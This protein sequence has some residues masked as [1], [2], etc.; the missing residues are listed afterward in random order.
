MGECGVSRSDGK[1][2]H[3][4]GSCREGEH[5]RRLESAARRHRAGGG[6]ANQMIRAAALGAILCLRAAAQGPACAVSGTVVD[7]ANKPVGKARVLA[8]GPNYS[9]WKSTDKSGFFCFDHIEP[10]S[11]RLSVEKAGYIS[12][13]RRVTIDPEDQSARPPL[14]IA[15]SAEAAISGVVLDS[16][17]EPIPGAAVS[18]WTRART[19]KGF[20]PNSEEGADTGPD[21]AFSF[22]DLFPG[23]YY[24]SASHKDALQ[25]GVVFPILDS[26]GRPPSEIEMETFY[27]GSLT[28]A[29][30]TPLTLKPGQNVNNLI[31]MVRK[32]AVRRLAGRAN[33]PP[34]TASLILHE[35]TETSSNSGG[36]IPIGADGSFSR[37]GLAPARY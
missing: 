15:I 18:V 34:S 32:T 12:A 16:Y 21:G 6:G 14:R 31:L 4:S 10:G 11:Y 8:A 26:Q 9:L 33:A 37:D 35:D 29:G 3:G 30:A 22:S 27:G 13:H 2:G 17:G 20:T 36:I 5:A 24:L 28:F 23:V 19:A 25:R 7:S 1:P